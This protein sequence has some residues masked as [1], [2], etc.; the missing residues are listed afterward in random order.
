MLHIYIIAAWKRRRMKIRTKAAKVRKDIR[1]RPLSS[2]AFCL[3]WYPPDTTTT[4]IIITIIII[5][6][7]AWLTKGRQSVF[8]ISCL[9]FYVLEKR[10]KEMLV[11]SFFL[12][13]F[14][15]LFLR[16]L[17]VIS[18][19]FYGME[20]M[21]DWWIDGTG[22]VEWLLVCLLACLKRKGA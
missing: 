22:W 4:R 17:T 11:S 20:R 9:G 2:W 21:M 5:I 8:G 16:L 12:I 3:I 6:I 7:I 15:Y 1:S 10:G 19:F 13:S 14:L 18:V